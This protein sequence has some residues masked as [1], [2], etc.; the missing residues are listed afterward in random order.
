MQAFWHPATP[1][2]LLAAGN[3]IQSMGEILMLTG[4]ESVTNFLLHFQAS[5]I[6]K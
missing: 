5:Q 6:N 2:V 3:D 1:E 4:N